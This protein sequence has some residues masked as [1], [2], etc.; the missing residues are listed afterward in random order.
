MLK[1]SSV[2]VERAF[3]IPERAARSG[4]STQSDS[5]GLSSSAPPKLGQASL[6]LLLRILSSVT[7]WIYDK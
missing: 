5:P 6:G 7:G 4:I 2:H 3:T 1:S